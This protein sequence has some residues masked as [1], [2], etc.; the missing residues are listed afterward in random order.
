MSGVTCSNL[1][2]KPGQRVAVKGDVQQGAKSFVINLG[3]NKDDL[4]LHFNA[5]FDIHGDVRT[6]VCNSKNKGQ[7]GKEHRESNFP[8]QEGSPT[9]V[10]FV[11]DKK[12]TTITLPGNI[13]F[14]V[15]NE[16]GFEGIDFV[17]TDGDIAFKGLTLA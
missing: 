6:I 11:H 5:R 8:F 9:E 4:L 12:E 2:L 3:K 10:A 16:T 1:Q 15:P 17:C 7:W 14:K 13:T